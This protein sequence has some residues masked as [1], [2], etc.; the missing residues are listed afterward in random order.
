MPRP[1]S[2]QGYK[3]DHETRFK[4]TIVKED[5]S[6]FTRLLSQLQPSQPVVTLKPVTEWLMTRADNQMGLDYYDFRVALRNA[7]PKPVREFLLE[8]EIPRRYMQEG[9]SV[10]AEVQS[11]RAGYRLFRS[12]IEQSFPPHVIYPGD[13]R[14]VVQLSYIIKRQHYLQG[15]PEGIRVRVFSGDELVS[16]T[17]Y[18]IT[19]M[20][21][22]ERVGMLLGPR[23]RAIKKI[24]QAARDFIGTDD[25][26]VTDVTIYL[27]D[28]PI[29]GTRGVR[30]DDADNMMMA[31]AK[32]RLIVIE[33]ED[34]TSVRITDEGVR[35]AT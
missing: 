2:L 32:A 23:I 3:R 16:E 13:T 4:N 6:Q 10:H 7:G 33:S 25:G 24:Y 26:D 5:I 34:A 9:S 29:T 8:V 17:E 12:T 14:P 18:P 19:E 1:A 15:I 21:N 11:R 20:L 22:A 35:I 30:L 28:G 31:L 27:A